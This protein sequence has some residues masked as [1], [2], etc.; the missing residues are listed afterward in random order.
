MYEVKKID[1]SVVKSSDQTLVSASR[2]ITEFFVLDMPA[3]AAFLLKVGNNA[4][5]IPITRPFTMEPTDEQESNNGL[6]WQN[7]LAQA[8]V[9]I[10]IVVVFGSAGVQLNTV[11]T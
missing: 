4:D 6:Y 7:E 10:T 5:F 11:L 1:L 3:G 8:G 2:R 9:I